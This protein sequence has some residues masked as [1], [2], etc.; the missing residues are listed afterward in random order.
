MHHNH[1][2]NYF[3]LGL[4][5]GTEMAL[6]VDDVL[7]SLRGDNQV[8]AYGFEAC[9]KHFAECSTRFAG[10]GDR[11]KIFHGAIAGKDGPVMLYHAS[12]PLGHSI[13]DS[14]GNVSKG[15]HETVKGIR[16]SDFLEKVSA[17]G[18]FNILRYNI[19]GAEWD[20]INDLLQRDML[21]DI[22]VFCGSD[23][24]KDM[25]KVAELREKVA[26]HKQILE[27]NGINVHYF[28][29]VETQSIKAIIEEQYERHI[30]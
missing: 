20:L 9:K 24:G 1:R 7:P 15:R 19:E 21:K 14:K 26:E 13:Y 29:G 6:M 12:T 11:V 30:S 28:C 16:F 8:C 4:Y 3:D 17:P 10:Y 25:G 23:V 5:R 22:D 2:I 27:A 18:D